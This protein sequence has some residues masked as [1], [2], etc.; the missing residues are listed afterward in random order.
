MIR[1][2]LAGEPGPPR[3]I[4]LVNAAAAL[5]VAGLAQDLMAGTRLAADAID[6]QRAAN[7]LAALVAVSNR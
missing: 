5:L 1:G 3:D 6:S 7:A 2:V 4:T